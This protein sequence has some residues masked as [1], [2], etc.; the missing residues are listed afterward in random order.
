MSRPALKVEIQMTGDQQ[1]KLG[2]VRLS[3]TAARRQA[4]GDG[5]Q[6]ALAVIKG[7]YQAKGRPFWVNPALPTHGPGRKESIRV[8]SPGRARTQW[9]RSTDTAWAMR[10]PNSHAVNFTNGTI[11]LAHKVT[12]GTIRAKRK[13]FLTI[14]LDPRAHG[15]T[16][17]T[18]SRTI[19]PLFAAKGMLMF[20]DEQTA[21]VKAAY[22]LKKS[23]TQRPWPG[24]LP[25]EAS[26][27]DTFIDEALDS[28]I[29][30]FETP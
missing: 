5:G 23:I 14:P 12:G 22:A 4:I 19:A 30:S 26:Y 16:A 28:L 13:K 25:P 18:F 1:A 21:D 6:A 10:Q 11:G 3:S 7:Y 8:W 20:V 17:K 24:A 27:L 15:L 9:W 29:D 2:L